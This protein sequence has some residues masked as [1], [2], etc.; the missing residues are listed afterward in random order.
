MKKTVIGSKYTFI[1]LMLAGGFF[2]SCQKTKIQFGEAYVDNS[3]SNIILVDTLTPQLSTVYT[4]SVSTSA[5][6]KI[7]VGSYVDNSFGKITAKSFFEVSP[8]AVADISTSASFDSLELIIRPDKSYYG[9]T[10][11]ATKLSV[12]QLTNNLTFPLYQTQFYNNTDFAVNSTPLGSFDALI[13]PSHTDSV[14]IRLSD[15]KGQEL[16][17]LYRAKDASMQSTTNFL[18]Y[19]KGLQISPSP[20]GM[21]AVY[22]FNDSAIMRLHYHVTGVFTESKY[23]DFSFYNTDNTQFNQVKSD[24]T[25]TP[26]AVFNSTHKEVSS[27]ATNGEAY[28]QYITGFIPKIKFPSIRTLLLRPDYVK[29]LKADLII[30]TLNNSYN[31]YMPLPPKLYAVTTDLSNTFQSVLSNKADGSYQTG[32]LVLDPI[33][34]ENT[35]YTYDVTAYLQQQIQLTANNNGNGLL[36]TAPSPATISTFNRLV[37]GDKQNPKG[38]IQLKLYYVSVNP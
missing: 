10:T 34:Q 25:G 18:N 32:N 13:Y 35:A 8:P 23:L 14:A 28:L 11:F 22:G 27:T 3:Y 7:L 30:H 1:I 31:G 33:Y 29:I 17:N 36:L 37:I 5:S 19:F 20:A 16:F 9:D 15:A 21:H 26:L 2:T 12:Y 38:S 24:R 6:G 4:D